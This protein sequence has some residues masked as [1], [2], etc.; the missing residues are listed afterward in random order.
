MAISNGYA[1]LAQFKAMP[2]IESVDTADDSYIEDLIT[3]ASR[4]IDGYCGGRAFYARTETRYFDYTAERQLDVDDDLLAITTLTNGDATTIA[5]AEYLLMN[6]SSAPYFAIRLKQ[7]SSVVWTLDSDGNSDSVISVAGSWGYIDRA[8]TDARSVRVIRETEAA[9]LA[10]AY[11]EYKKRHGVGV[12]GV[13]Q[14]TAAGVVI[15]PAGIPAD[16]ERRIRRY[17]RGH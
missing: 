4:D 13:A 11:S 14:V 10:M 9:C 17:R 1:T 12:E 15:T 7:S 8:G 6:K 16:A 2:G 5:A 3:R